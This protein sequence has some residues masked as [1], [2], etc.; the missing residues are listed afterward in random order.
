MTFNTDEYQSQDLMAAMEKA[1]E[2]LYRDPPPIEEIW[3]CK[4]KVI[5]KYYAEQ[6]QFAE[7]PPPTPAPWP[8]VPI[9]QSVIVGHQPMISKRA[10]R[11]NRRK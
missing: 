8:T 6:K 9:P 1:L 4:K 7:N 11:R 5:D 2:I 3:A 10:R